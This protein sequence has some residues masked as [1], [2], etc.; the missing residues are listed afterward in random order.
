MSEEKNSTMNQYLT[1]TL[2]KDIYAL[3]ISSVR[4]GVGV[5]PHNQDS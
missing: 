1:F 5:N 2:N 3:D 4:E